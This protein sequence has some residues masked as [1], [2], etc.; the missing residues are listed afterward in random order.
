MNENII[1]APD[2]ALGLFPDAP[3]DFRRHDS[4]S[5][6]YE[7]LGDSLLVVCSARVESDGKRWIH[8]SCSRPNRLP[9]WQDVRRVKDV[10]IGKDRRAIQVLPPAAEYVNIH[11]H[12]LHLWS[13][14][15]GDGLPDFRVMGQI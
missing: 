13:C 10:F 15:D 8:V 7:K 2:W 5:L 14:L 11:P 4:P 12:C 9:T 6:H 3:L 1:D